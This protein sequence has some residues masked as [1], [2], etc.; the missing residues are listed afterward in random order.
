MWGLPV[1]H[2]WR[3]AVESGSLTGPRMVIGSRIVDG[4]AP[5]WPESISVRNEQEAREA[6]RQS[7]AEGAEFIKVYD[8]LPREA[9]FALV[10]ESK[11]QGL[12][13]AGHVP[14]LVSAG[15]AADAGMKSMEHLTGILQASSSKETELRSLLR[16]TPENRRASSDPRFG[17]EARR[18]MRDSFSLEKEKA[19]LKHLKARGS[20]AALTSHT[21]DNGNKTLDRMG[22][23]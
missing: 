17:L 20:K 1:H 15:E 7:K 10:N 12:S 13:F 11:K 16:A 5:V 8:L 19:L 21:P 14:Q 2:E 6:V 23:G 9:F 18:L 3:M 22:I 4:R